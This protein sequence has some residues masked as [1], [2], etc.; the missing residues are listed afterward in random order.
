MLL[1]ALTLAAAMAHSTPTAAAAGSRVEVKT[2]LGTVVCT[3]SP[4]SCVHVSCKTLDS[5]RSRE[6][7]S[8]PLQVGERTQL[9]TA[10]RSRQVEVQLFRGVPY[11][12]PPTDEHRWKPPRCSPS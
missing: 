8:A 5:R 10:Q 12:Q 4:A 6:L 7:A 2:S 1:F 3:V 11:A 9:H